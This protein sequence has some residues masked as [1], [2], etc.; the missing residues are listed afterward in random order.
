MLTDRELQSLRNMGNEAEAA[1]DEIAELRHAAA[2]HAAQADARI[3]ELEA[4]L[5]KSRRQVA[6]WVKLCD[7]VTLH[8]NLLRGIPC[9]L[10]RAT[11]LHLA[12][13]EPGPQS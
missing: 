5:A 13:D 8:V 1:A 7:P 4:A 2:E 6:E 12:G 3:A 11:F 9:K 10:D